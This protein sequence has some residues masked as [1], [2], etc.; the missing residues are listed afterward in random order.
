MVVAGCTAGTAGTVGTRAAC[1]TG[2]RGSMNPGCRG[3]K[4]VGCMQRRM[5][6]SHTG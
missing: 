6:F 5:G 1:L 3:C 4:P 2:G